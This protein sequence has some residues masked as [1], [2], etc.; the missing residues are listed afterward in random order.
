VPIYLTEFGVQSRPNRF[1]GVPVAQQ[2]EWDAIAERLS[3]SNAR[4]AGFSQYLLRDDPVGGAP[5]ASVH[6]GTIGFQTG[7]EYLSGKLKPLYFGWPVPLTVSKHGRAFSLWGLVRPATGVTRV[8]VL[9][10]GAHARRYRVLST[11]T[12]DSLGRWSTS[13]SVRGAHWRVRW[14]SPT[15]VSYEGPPISA[16]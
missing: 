14:S 12:T 7:L 11:V 15:G 9:V 8:T 2:A 6:G 13:S 5:G 1:L 4:V 16:S 10:A 3:W